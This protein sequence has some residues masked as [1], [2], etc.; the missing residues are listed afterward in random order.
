M[1]PDIAWSGPRPV[2]STHGARSPCA[3]SSSNVSVSQ[4]RAVSERA[5]AE[6]EQPA[7]AE[8]RIGASAEPEARRRPEL[9]AEH[10][11]GDVGIRHELVELPL[12]RLAQLGG[13]RGA[14]GRE[15]HARAVREHR[16]SRQVGVQVLDAEPVEVGLQL[17]VGRRAGPERV[18]R[19]EDL[20][21]E[22]RRGEAVDRLD[23]A[24]EPVVPLE[25]AAAPAGLGEQCRSS[26]R[27]DPAADED[28]V[29]AG[30]ASTLTWVDMSASDVR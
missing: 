20:V 14:V 16:A 29:E 3:R 18:P 12:P 7:A 11:E 22:A 25:H 5:A 1:K 27:V 6:L 21:R 19:A 10:A 9:G 17:R 23:R 15:E 2:C 26:E 4:S 13:V 8:P 24:A 28:R 30:H